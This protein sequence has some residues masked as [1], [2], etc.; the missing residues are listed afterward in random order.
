MGAQSPH[1]W[2]RA[3]AA[4]DALL[5][6]GLTPVMRFCPDGSVEVT[7]GAPVAQPPENE[8]DAPAQEGEW[9]V[10][11]DAIKQAE[12][13]IARRHARKVEG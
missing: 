3:R 13:A 11:P 7:V 9:K 8:H 6:H 12:S 5:E 1:V 4:M 2:K 10:D